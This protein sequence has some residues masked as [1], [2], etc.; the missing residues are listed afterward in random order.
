MRPDPFHID[1][2]FIAGRHNRPLC[3]A[4]CPFRHSRPVVNPENGI[5][6]ELREQTV[7]D[8]GARAG[9]AFLGRLEN[10]DNRPVEIAMLR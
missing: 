7:L 2:E 6:G 5:N 9:A 8:H 4:E 1:T 3:H 10:K